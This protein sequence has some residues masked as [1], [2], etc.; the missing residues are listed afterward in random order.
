M[1]SLRLETIASVVNSRPAILA[2]LT[3]ALTR[4]LVKPL[5]DITNGAKNIS[6]HNL[7]FRLNTRFRN[8]EL[9]DLART[10][11]IMLDRL[12][13]AFET[14]KN[15]ISN[16]SHELNTPLTAI[17]GTTDVI[18][19]KPREQSEYVDCLKTLQAEAYKLETKTRALLLLAQSGFVNRTMNLDIIRSDELVIE[20]KKTV[21]QLY[22][23]C[24]IMIDFSLL[25]D[26]PEKLKLRGN[27]Q[28]LHLAL[29]NIVAN[30]CKYARFE[31]IKIALTSTN[32]HVVFLVV[33]KGI[34]IPSAEIRFIY[35]PFFRGSNVSLIEGYGIGLPLSRNVIKMHHGEIE[36]SSIENEGTTVQVKIPIAIL[37][38]APGRTDNREKKAK[39][40]R[41]SH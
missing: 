22:P 9:G 41:A 21:Q 13:A 10:F 30:A 40:R 33:D 7:N 38:S 2:A 31:T 35:E 1:S 15:F 25:P 26:I 19:S 20:V 8:D 23:E 11:N 4:T 6:A 28:L 12:E 27:H 5:L 39:K 17:I 36:V 29:T 32:E 16:A 3:Y 18:L 34:G 14:Q 37:N 24:H